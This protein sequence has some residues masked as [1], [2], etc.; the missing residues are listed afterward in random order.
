MNTIQFVLS[1]VVVP[2]II[3]IGIIN[4]KSKGN[5]KSLAMMVMV[6]GIFYFY[7][8]IASFVGYLNVETDRYIVGYTI[9]LAII[10]GAS[11]VYDGILL[12]KDKRH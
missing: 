5:V 9:S 4:G 8:A 1:Y 3:S 10:E 2:L 11:A 12:I 7:L 6:K